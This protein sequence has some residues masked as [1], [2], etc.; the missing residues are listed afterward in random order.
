M[1]SRFFAV[2][3]RNPQK[4]TAW[5]HHPGIHDRC[6]IR[7]RCT[8]ARRRSER[9][10]EN[11]HK[12]RGCRSPP[13]SSASPT[14]GQERPEDSGVRTDRKEDRS[15]WWWCC[16]PSPSFS[17]TFCLFVI[18][19]GVR[20]TGA[21]AFY[22]PPSP[23]PSVSRHGAQGRGRSC[24]GQHDEGSGCW[25]PPPTPRATPSLF[26]VSGDLARAR[27]EW[28]MAWYRPGA[29]SLTDYPGLGTPGYAPR[30]DRRQRGH[31]HVGAGRRPGVLWTGCSIG[32]RAEVGPSIGCAGRSAAR[33]DPY[34][35]DAEQVARTAAAAAI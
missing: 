28:R 2:R 5:S 6:P 3:L 24:G 7:G 13:W 22:D 29:Q 12:C 9:D 19:R 33:G 14:P 15:R 27:A 23:L 30:L 17:R 11:S 35:R 16:P 31:F 1:C 8:P 32:C 18:A 26:V 4:A 20:V 25:A 34:H 10:A 21:S